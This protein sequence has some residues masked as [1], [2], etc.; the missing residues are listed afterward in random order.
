M[1]FSSGINCPPYE[2]A[3]GYLQTT[4]GC[5]HN[6]CL[7]CTKVFVTDIVNLLTRMRKQSHQYV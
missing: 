6:H 3:D 2:S 7:F 4:E 1:H 5:S